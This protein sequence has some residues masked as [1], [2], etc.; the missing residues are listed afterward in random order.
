MQPTSLPQLSQRSLM[1]CA[2]FDGHETQLKAYYIPRKNEALKD[3]PRTKSKLQNGQLL[4]V[5]MPLSGCWQGQKGRA[6]QVQLL[7]FLRHLG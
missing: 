7:A 4:S 5:L 3:P 6:L 2:D 1:D